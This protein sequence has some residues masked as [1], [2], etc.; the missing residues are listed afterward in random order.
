M[1]ALTGILFG[2]TAASSAAAADAGYTLHPDRPKQ[3]IRGIG[4]EI[5]SDSIGSG[6][7][8]LPENQ[9]AV[10][11]DLTPGER[12]RLANE[13][14]KGFRYC[15]VAGGL[16]WRGLDAEKKFLQPRWPDQLKELREL[17][18]TAGVE[19][20]SF[21]YWSPTP[22]WKANQSYVGKGPTDPENT[23]R[24][25]GPQFANDPVYHGDVDRFLKDFANAVV[26]DI[27]TL[28]AAGIRTSIWGLQNEPWVSNAHYSACRYAEPGDYVK[29]Y[30]TVARAIRAFDPGILLISDTEHDF[31]SKIATAMHDPEV[32]A[33]VDAYVV[34]TVG[35][36]SENVRS[37]HV[38]IRAELP[39]RPWFQNEYEY[40]RGGATPERCLNTVQH[41]MNSFQLGE[42]PTWFWIH[43]LKPFKNAEASGYSLGFW[44]SLEDAPAATVAAD[45]FRRWPEGPA[46]ANLPGQ[47]KG[48]EMISANRGDF[49][50]P[51][52]GFTFIV[53]QPVTVYLAVENRG[54]FRPGPEWTATGETARW[55]E[56]TDSIYSRDFPA[57]E[58]AIPAHPG[59][60]GGVFGAPHVAFVKPGTP[61]GFKAMIGINVPIQI[62]SEF[63]ALERAASE[64]KP[65][66][67]TYNRYNWNA[68]GSFVKHMPWD[69]VAIELSETFSDPDAR[70]FAFKR[71]NGKLTV[72]VSNRTASDRSFSINTAQPDARWKGFRYTPEAAGERT[73]GV[74]VGEQAG[75]L[76][77]PN[78]PP[79]TWEFWEQQ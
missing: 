59:E 34:H 4:F 29:A 64:L 20:V 5:Q 24:C 67:W 18:D 40:L 38:R 42:N 79:L 50:K 28:K 7:Q 52:I 63:L 55:N 44:K 37:V 54:G 6:N 68:V 43:A 75:R 9:I 35:S 77:Q 16:Y 76:L 45:G 61:A 41:I 32:A 10:P 53:N 11:R 17:L 51:A 14:L 65:G 30:R 73:E 62:R 22:F 31:P 26:T 57:G 12:V 21:E 47:L 58:I 3:V 19:G 46:F 15:R 2:L 13:M 25:F 78:L 27:K 1:R 39:L 69:S 48:L 74:P 72:V 56:R 66:H 70:I 71:P 33:L 60:E 8:G 49:A 23:L 36:P